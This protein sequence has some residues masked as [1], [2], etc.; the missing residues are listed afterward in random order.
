MKLEID[1]DGSRF[2]YNDDGLLHREDGPAVEGNNGYRGWYENGD[3]I[4]CCYVN[5]TSWLAT[6]GDWVT[7]DIDQKRTV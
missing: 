1:D 4:G 3:L 5:S 2:W 6:H 7:N